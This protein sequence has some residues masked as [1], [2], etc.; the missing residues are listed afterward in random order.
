MIDDISYDKDVVLDIDFIDG[1]KLSIDNRENLTDIEEDLKNKKL[2]LGKAIIESVF[3]DM[4][5]FIIE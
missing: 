3:R 5:K 1:S 4:L 2:K